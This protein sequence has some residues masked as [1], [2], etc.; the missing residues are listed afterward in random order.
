MS[1]CKYCGA[2]IVRIKHMGGTA[3]C[4]AS[5]VTYWAVRDGDARTIYT[6]NGMTEQGTLTGNLRDAIG[7]GY[8][9]HTC[10]QKPIILK[11]RDSWS[12][13]VYEDLSGR[14]L[15]DVDPRKD[16]EPDI[17][18]K[19]GNAFNGEPCDPVEGDFDFIPY[20]DTW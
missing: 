14:L 11:G 19:Q 2:E 15:V 16:Q 1:K 4:W 13:P 10:N 3:V 20:R 6:P 9:P 8:L 7:I 17:C 5:P 12:R 18:T